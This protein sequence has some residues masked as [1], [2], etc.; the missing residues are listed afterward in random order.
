M[1][2]FTPSKLYNLLFLELQE[3][4]FSVSNILSQVSAANNLTLKKIETIL[5]G[6]PGC[7]HIVMCDSLSLAAQLLHQ[8]KLLE[9]IIR[10][11]RFKIL[12]KKS[13]IIL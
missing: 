6:E 4:Q 12:K 5:A 3:S 11:I 8:D 10:Y 7:R 13:F 9:S 1:D 2:I